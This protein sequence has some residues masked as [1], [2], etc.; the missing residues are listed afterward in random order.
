MKQLLSWI[1]LSTLAAP[2]FCAVTSGILTS[3]EVF[4][5]QTGP[6]TVAV[7]EY[8]AFDEAY[9]YSDETQYITSMQ[10]TISSG[11]QANTPISVIANPAYNNDIKRRESFTTSAD[12]LARRPLDATYTFAVNGNASETISIQGPGS[13]D[14]TF[15]KALPE[16]PVFSFLRGT[17]GSTALAGTWST[18]GGRSVFSFDASTVG[19]FRV[20]MSDA[21]MAAVGERFE[22]RFAVA[23]VTNGYSSLQ[24]GT[25]ENGA[26]GPTSGPDAIV[27]DGLD[28]TF[29]KGAASDKSDTDSTTFGFTPGRYYQIEGE[30]F[31][32]FNLTDNGSVEG[33]FVFGSTTSMVFYAAA[34]PEPSSYAVAS[35]VV[36]LAGAFLVRRRRR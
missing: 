22:Y 29:F 14:V 2:A 8:L 32:H 9:E 12:M 19:P 27:Y 11:N 31:N 23:D 6:G 30:F 16:A 35:G 18:I 13:T 10:L 25:D 15:E 7:R 3:V 20:H 5:D 24:N 36:A 21:V 26:W 28:L 4:N 1:G 33:A 17:S 34:I